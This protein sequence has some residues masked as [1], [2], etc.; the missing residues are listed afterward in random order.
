M[1]NKIENPYMLDHVVEISV[2]NFYA[3]DKETGM[4]YYSGTLAS[5]DLTNGAGDPEEV[6]GGWENDCYYVIPSANSFTLEVTDI[7][8]DQGLEATEFGGSLGEVGQKIIKSFHMPKSYTVYEGTKTITETESHYEVSADS[9]ALTIVADGAL[10][11][12]STEIEIS[13]VTPVL[14]GYTP[15]L[16]DKV[17]LITTTT[18]VETPI[19]YI[20]LANKPYE[21]EQVVGYNTKTNAKIETGNI[22]ADEDDAEGKKYL[23]KDDTILVG[24]KVFITGFY[25]QAS[26][27]TR[28][29]SIK[30][31]A[32]LREVLL[33]AELPLFDDSIN[34]VGYKQF[35]F[36]KAVLL[37]QN[38]G[39][40]GQSERK[41][42]E[43]VT[44]FKILKEIGESE[45]GR[46]M[47]LTPE[48]ALSEQ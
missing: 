8:N 46:I 3:F 33:V 26:E 32:S 17:K 40:N 14:A 48:E 38:A 13:S 1:A 4:E 23:I 11:D 41:G 2:A 28:Y 9:D 47:Y 29:S 45:L 24:D 34:I 25:F 6:K 39:S 18:D 27:K 20:T 43:K 5:H 12:A 10:V 30:S 37:T 21:G 19:K 7:F 15:N 36:P 44:S 31:M 16:G 22:V 42:V 35:I